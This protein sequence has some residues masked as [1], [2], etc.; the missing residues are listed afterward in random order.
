METSGAEIAKA[1]PETFTSDGI[2]KLLDRWTECKTGLSFR[3]QGVC[4]M[5]C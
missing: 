4:E 2:R 3:E 1:Q 5:Q